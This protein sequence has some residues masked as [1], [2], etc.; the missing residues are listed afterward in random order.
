L[1]TIYFRTRGGAKQGWGNIYRILLIYNLLKKN[2]RLLFIYEGNRE[3][4]QYLNQKKIKFLRLKEGISLKEEKK[5]ISKLYKPDLTIIEMLE[6][7]F[8]RQKIYK[9]IS[10]KLVVFD[11]IL[12]KKYCADLLVCAQKKYNE[13]KHKNSLIGYEYYPLRKEFKKYL[14]KQKNIKKKISNILICLGGSSYITAYKKLI[15]FFKKKNYNVTFV[16]GNEKEKIVK[17]KVKIKKFNFIKTTDDIAKLLFNS[18]LA[19]VGGGYI[20]I[21][22]AY[23][24]TPM[25]VFPVQKH[26]QKLVKNFK[27]FC[28]VPYLPSPKNTRPKDIEKMIKFY[29]HNKRNEIHKILKRKFKKNKFYQVLRKII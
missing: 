17:N 29:N 21:E 12:S 28:K 6:C 22:A 5:I 15:N 2:N 20:K 8:S 19:I 26:Q 18:D 7:N 16:F 27:K 14:N 10:K 4:N 24:N 9:N 3:V 13:K 11:D 23:M 25:V 1:K